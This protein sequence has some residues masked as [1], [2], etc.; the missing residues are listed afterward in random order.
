[1]DKICNVF[2]E[3][4]RRGWKG[5]RRPQGKRKGVERLERAERMENVPGEASGCED[6][7][8][9]LSILG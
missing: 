1:M 8:E 3:L 7:P 5:G 2:E 9:F 6:P 4:G